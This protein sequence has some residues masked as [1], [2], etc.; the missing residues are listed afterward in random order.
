MKGENHMTKDIEEITKLL[1]LEK[2]Y[3]LVK[4][5][6]AYVKAYIHYKSKRSA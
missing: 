6:L 1:E 3:I 4:K 2:D 5:V